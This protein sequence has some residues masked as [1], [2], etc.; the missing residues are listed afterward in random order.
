M[1]IIKHGTPQPPKQDMIAEC[2]T[3]GCVFTF[4]DHEAEEMPNNGG[5]RVF[6]TNCPECGGGAAFDTGYPRDNDKDRELN[7]KV[8]AEHAALRAL[9]Q[10]EV[11]KG[12]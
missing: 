6:F 10:P 1:K 12:M 9:V 4:G 11:L 8:L 2:R 3:C 7:Q 5:G